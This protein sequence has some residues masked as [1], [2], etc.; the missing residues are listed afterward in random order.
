MSNL[1]T[2]Q[3]PNVPQINSVNSCHRVSVLFSGQLPNVP[4]I[5]L[6]KYLTHGVCFNHYSIPKTNQNNY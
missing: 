2:V 4:Q 5:D 1:I 6:V 3:L